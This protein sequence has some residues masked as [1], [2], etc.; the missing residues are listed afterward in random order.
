MTTLAS[1]MSKFATFALFVVCGF[2]YEQLSLNQKVGGSVQCSAVNELSWPW[3]RYFTLNCGDVLLNYHL[4]TI[5]CVYACF[6]DLRPSSEDFL[7]TAN[8]W[9]NTTLDLV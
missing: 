9:R 3:G 4:L 6:G 2:I 8:F 1:I 7:I 5:M